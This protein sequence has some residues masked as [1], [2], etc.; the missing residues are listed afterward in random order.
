VRRRPCVLVVDDDTAIQELFTTVFR[1]SG[2]DVRHAVNGLGALRE[3]ERHPPDAVILDLDLPFLN[4]LEVHEELASRP[5]TQ[6]VPVII[7]TGTD[8]ESPVPAFATLRKPVDA[9]ELIPVL[10]AAI[11]KIP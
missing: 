4:G 11:M 5:E 6:Q 8:W 2:F 3:I 1:F 7:V 9:T 10:Q